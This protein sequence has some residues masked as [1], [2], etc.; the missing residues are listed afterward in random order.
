MGVSPIFTTTS[1][2]SELLW[3]TEHVS[4]RSEPIQRPCVCSDRYWRGWSRC[5]VITFLQ[6]DPR[7][8]RRRLCWLTCRPNTFSRHRSLALQSDHTQRELRELVKLMWFFFLRFI[9]VQE[10]TRTIS[11]PVQIGFVPSPRRYVSAAVTASRFSLERPKET[12]RN[13]LAST[14]LTVML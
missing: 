5:L 10:T 1:D 11:L 14:A 13:S 6:D 9:E 8:W 2:D 3:N 4:S 7:A 12:T